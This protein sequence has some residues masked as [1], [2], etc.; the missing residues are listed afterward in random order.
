MNREKLEGLLDLGQQVL[1]EIEDTPYGDSLGRF[2][3]EQ[4]MIE[5][6]RG[7]GYSVR[8]NLGENPVSH[9]CAAC[10]KTVPGGEGCWAQELVFCSPYCV[11]RF[12]QES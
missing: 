7:V 11:E 3:L 5:F 2:E 1:Y 10:H 12:Y 6:L 4:A 8:P 9:S